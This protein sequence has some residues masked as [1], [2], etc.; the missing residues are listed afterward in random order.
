MHLPRVQLL[1]VSPA[2]SVLFGRRQGAVVKL[3]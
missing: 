2:F 3:L 1:F